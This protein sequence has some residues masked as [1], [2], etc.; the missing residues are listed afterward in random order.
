M[1]VAVIFYMMSSS[2]FAF[3]GYFK[4]ADSILSRTRKLVEELKGRN[5]I[6]HFT[7]SFRLGTSSPQGC[8]LM[9]Q[10]YDR[11][12]VAAGERIGEIY[13]AGGYRVAHLYMKLYQGKFDEFEDMLGNHFNLWKNYEYDIVKAMHIF[14]DD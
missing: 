7:I 8:G 10:N 3:L 11:S 13:Y 6:A 12:V 1:E 14:V 5:L 4:L 9:R 2:L